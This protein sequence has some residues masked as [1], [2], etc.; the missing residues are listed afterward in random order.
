MIERRTYCRICPVLCGLVVTV[1]GD[2]VLRVRGDDDHPISHGYTCPKGRAMGAFHHHPLRLDH[3]ELRLDGTTTRPGWDSVLDDL[4]GRIRTAVEESG[5]DA[6]GVYHG[7]WSWFDALGKRAC[8][9]ILDRIGS[10]SRYSA[11]TVDGVN[12]SYVAERMGGSS[13]LIAQLDPDAPALVVLIGT[14]PLVSHGHSMGLADPVARLRAFAARD[15]LWVVDPVR[16]E[17]ARLANRHLAPRAGSDPFVV[18]HLVRELLADGADREYLADH[19]SGVAELTA[20]VEPFTRD[21]V[22]A[23][24]GLA[25]GDLADLVDAI[26][27]AGR[28]T[29]L[30]GTGITMAR[31]G[32]L[33]EWLVWALNAV[34]GSWERPGGP[35]CN[36]GYLLRY[37]HRG[38]GPAGGSA[39]PGPA[40]RPDLP[41]RFWERPCA[42]LADEIE[43]GN[44]RVL[45][46]IG[47][48][49]ICSLPDAA[50]LGAAFGK[51]DAL[52]VGDVIESDTVR[53]ATH[54]LASAGQLERTDISFL[55]DVFPNV[56]S[57]QHT[58][59]VVA[60]AAGRRPLWWVFAQLG[61]RLGIDALPDSLD[62]DTCSDADIVRAT[63]RR[64]PSPVEGFADGPT[65]FLADDPRPR[66]WVREHILPEGRWQLALPELLER[67]ATLAEPAPLV[68]TPRRVMRR[69]N[70][71]LRDVHAPGG[72]LGPT[73]VW[74]HPDDAAANGLLGAES[75]VVRSA[76]GEL[77]APLRV[78][79]D[80]CVGT[81]SV[82][83]GLP[84]GQNVS[85]LTTGAL[86][87]TE[88]L[89]GMV[90][91][92]GLPVSIGPVPV[93]A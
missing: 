12:R 20:A 93:P 90:T 83:H 34:T 16:T 27:T 17:T 67:L 19:A 21:R 15:S 73:E 24:T 54:V 1:D 2:T 40:S 53:F 58:P 65:V 31:D 75:L 87:T 45:F 22:A 52:A 48:N 51:L 80:V 72:R 30:S 46:V 44:L 10:R 42:G 70:S 25:P 82:P 39:A 59:P 26:R 57:A 55:G 36:P 38:P 66:G 43:A 11:L 35:W 56:M 84:T 23:A 41:G 68:L 81:V 71:A 76:T 6:V 85:N 5:P 32:V 88:P 91:Q 47:G 37:D 13:N 86:G 79:T 63:V 9:R 77:V 50:G 29:V 28:A 78:T 49:P 7:T 92:S 60:P 3:P 74:I 18:A 89:T 4:A 14:N 62:P 69:M 64:T 61:R 33:T 8:D